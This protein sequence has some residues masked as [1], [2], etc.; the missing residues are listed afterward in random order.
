[1]LSLPLT[2]AAP[3]EP[4]P[5]TEE[6]PAAFTGR[7]TQAVQEWIELYPSP[8]SEH[9]LV[10]DAQRQRAM[11]FGGLAANSA[12]AFSDSLWALED[13][14]LYGADS[15]WREVKLQGV[16]PAPRSGHTALMDQANDRMIVFGGA[17][18]DALNDVWVLANASSSAGPMEWV[19]ITP[20][21]PA[22]APRKFH[23]AVY[24][25]AENRM[26]I[27]GG[28]SSQYT[29][30][31]DA[32]VLANAN[33]LGGAATW[34]NLTPGGSPPSARY[35]HVAY[36][37]PGS[38]WM[39]VI[40][41]APAE[42][43]ADVWVL[44]N[45]TGTSGFAQWMKLWTLG[46]TPAGRHTHSAA[47]D[48]GLDR[49]VV[50]GGRNY[51][52]L[53]DVWWL[54]NATGRGAV[55]P[56]WTQV[57]PSGVACL[58]R[59]SHATAYDAPQDRMLVY[60]GS[61]EE[62]WTVMA[63]GDLCALR[64]A[65]GASGSPVWE[66]LRPAGDV[67][68]RRYWHTAVHDPGTDRMIVYAGWNSSVTDDVWVLTNASGTGGPSRWIEIPVS[69]STPVG[70]VMHT[71]VYD[72][73]SNRMVVYGGLHKYGDVK[74]EVWVLNNANGLGG[75]AGWTLL[76]PSGQ[77][78]PLR[79]E[80]SATYDAANDRMTVFGG[81]GWQA[82]P[83]KNDVWVLVNATVRGG[84]PSWVELNP[85]GTRPSPRGEHVAVYD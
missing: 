62:S 40:G 48:V 4:P 59:W 50:F 30:Y 6:G 72:P 69:G 3:P 31:N 25:T 16:R 51:S 84:P 45:A 34:T 26:V 85:A 65:S 53:D 81:G 57:A 44:T 24:D 43:L 68:M 54:E 46:G 73:G 74:P 9:S 82:E 41:G 15:Y 64:G 17:N 7:D 75:P 63:I 76:S 58:G 21:G 55:S 18:V 8:R 71:A 23:S 14:G 77:A 49:L 13:A 67:P 52:Q 47:Y 80:H 36:L 70:R 20:A 1:M 11:V 39:G 38:N 66:R 42:S 78:R 79:S 10:Y 33:G 27:F 12:M 37:H 2:P 56:K 28:I 22:P 61:H 19:E 32:W 83:Y 60:G 5:T 35:G 29:P